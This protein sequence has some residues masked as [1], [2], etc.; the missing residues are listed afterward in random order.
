MHNTPVHPGHAYSVLTAQCTRLSALLSA[1]HPQTNTLRPAAMFLLKQLHRARGVSFV[2][3]SLQREPFQSSAWFQSWFQTG[4]VVLQRFCGDGKLP[5]LNPFVTMP[6]W[7]AAQAAVG[8][9]LSQ[10]CSLQQNGKV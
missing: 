4:D 1:A 10:V 3:A 6:L 5:S 8:S 2:R 9:A 7:P